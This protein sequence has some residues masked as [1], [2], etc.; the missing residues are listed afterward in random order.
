[1]HCIAEARPALTH[2]RNVLDELPLDCRGEV[3]RLPSRPFTLP[4]VGRRSGDNASN[5]VAAM[6]DNDSF[7]TDDSTAL[8]E[9]QAALED[10][11][12]RIADT[13]A[14]VVVVNH[15][16]GLYEL[17]AIHLSS[18]PP[19]LDD[20]SLAIDALTALVERLGD[21]LGDDTA[22]MRDAL[23][24]IQMVYVQMKSRA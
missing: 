1:M 3:E 6:S 20:A 8:S 17:A 14:Q 7:G 13:P 12:R 4:D 15:L 24:N 19:K 9:A 21:R 18:V 2:R 10:A 16:M 23:S 11:R 5:S 22:T